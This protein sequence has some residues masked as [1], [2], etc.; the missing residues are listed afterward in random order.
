MVL[1]EV[2]GSVEDVL[3]KA[4]QLRLDQGLG[5]SIDEINLVVLLGAALGVDVALVHGL[6]GVRDVSVARH[7]LLEASADDPVN[8]ML[9]LGFWPQ[10][11]AKL[12]SK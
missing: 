3:V 7:V 1:D 11:Y 8:E 6:D 5:L 4:L 10:K 2:D 9:S 12:G